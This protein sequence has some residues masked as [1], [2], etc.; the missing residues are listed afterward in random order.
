MSTGQWT[1]L[2]HGPIE[3]PYDHDLDAEK[4]KEANSGLNT[5]HGDRT[6]QVVE[7]NERP[8][9]QTARDVQC[10]SLRI[11]KQPRSNG[12]ALLTDQRGANTNKI[13]MRRSGKKPTATSTARLL[14]IMPM[15]SLRAALP[16]DQ[17][18]TLGR[19]ANNIEASGQKGWM[20]NAGGSE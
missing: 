8:S 9:E 15:E 5:Q 12:V 10:W 11:R 7:P 16:T 6:T 20:F 19:G 3:G 2:A 4:W 17:T 18:T 14:R 13:L 1:R